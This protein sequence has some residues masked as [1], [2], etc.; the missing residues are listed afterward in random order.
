MNKKYEILEEIGVG[1][2]STVYKCK[3][4]QNSKFFAAKIIDTRKMNNKQT[5]KIL[6]EVKINK[7]LK[8]ENIVKLIEHFFDNFKYTLVL[9]YLSGGELF[10]AI[11]K[12]K[13]INENTVNI[14][15]KQ[16]L[17]AIDY[18]HTNN[19]V[20]RDIKPENI[21]LT[22]KELQSSTVSLPSKSKETIS[23][24]PM[25]K[26]SDFG[27]AIEVKDDLMHDY[28]YAGTPS[29]MAPEMLKQ[30]A[31]NKAI[32]LWS[33]GIITYIMI[34]G[35]SPFSGDSLEDY[36]KDVFNKQLVF[37]SPEWDSISD[38]SKDLI[39]QLLMINQVYRISAKNALEH[40]WIKFRK[41]VSLTK[42]PDTVE[43]LKKFNALRK[44]RAAALAS[45][46]TTIIAFPS[47]DKLD[48]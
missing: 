8:H 17:S 28:G 15:V 7:K 10:D 38:E 11:I 31:H 35:Y 14:L 21:L 41:Q 33:L 4:K 2:F 26:I 45:L 13:H 27:L 24:K 47:L 37:P 36:I 19:I 42:L 46:V 3:S 22:S 44:F 25:I 40:P 23:S 32:D 20:H 43:R 34:C 9:E 5:K 16:I 48:Q 39:K 1:G 6:L 12:S 29:Y 30:T 18:M